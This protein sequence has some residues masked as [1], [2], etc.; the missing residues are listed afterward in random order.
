[1]RTHACAHIHTLHTHTNHAKRG[2]VATRK[3]GSRT[4]QTT[5][6]ASYTPVRSHA[7]TAN[8]QA[9]AACDNWIK[10]GAGDAAG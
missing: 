4:H 1:M 3:S 6:A 9:T 5:R 2:H 8:R 10:R 7:S